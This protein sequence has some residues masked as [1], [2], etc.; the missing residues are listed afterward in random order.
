MSDIQSACEKFA[1]AFSNSQQAMG[2]L[3]YVVDPINVIHS[4][5][6][7]LSIEHEFFYKHL[8]M[9][10]SPTVGGDMFIQLYA[11]EELEQRQ[12]GWRWD[13]R[14]KKEIASWNK[15]WTVFADRN[16]DAI[17]SDASSNEVSRVYGAIQ[18][19]RVL[20]ADSLADF[21]RAMS[22]C[23]T[24]EEVTFANET[25]NDDMSYK[26]EFL[27]LLHRSLSSEIPGVNG[28]GFFEFFFE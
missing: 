15:C 3:E 23:M 6:I 12:V 20:I 22:T 11:P 2:L 7:T 27:D 1:N 19:K 4:P 21:L 26:S 13:G 25:R 18:S 8:R 14:T 5:Q 24:A 16:G 17:Y 28:E 10:D 9:S